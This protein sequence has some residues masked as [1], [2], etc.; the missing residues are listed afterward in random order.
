VSLILPS[1]A[2]HDFTLALDVQ[3]YF[4]AEYDVQMIFD[5]G[6]ARP[7]SLETRDV[8][9]VSRFNG[10]PDQPEFEVWFP[11][12]TLTPK[13]EREALDVLGRI[14]GTTLDTSGF[15]KKVQGDEVLEPLVMEHYGFKRLARAN[16]Y[17][18]A[19][20]RIAHSRISHDPTKKRMVQDIRKSWGTAW[21][22]EGVTY[23][24]YPRPEVLAEVEPQALREL[25]LSL[26]K[27]EYIT[28]L[29]KHVTDNP[30]FLAHM[31]T[32]EPE[33]FLERALG[34]RGIGPSLAQMLLLSRGSSHAVLA[35]RLVKKQ[36][37][38][39]RA[40]IFPR[41]GVDVNEATKAQTLDILARIEGYEALTTSYVYF[42][43][44]NE[45]LRKKHE[46]DSSL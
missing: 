45:E 7:L 44:V 9:S 4:E 8:L 37:K 13:E 28:G 34:I 17:E 6:Y 12:E 36:D 43:W 5:A 40:W 42:D 3:H 27:G 30:D 11:Q 46:K 2:P 14:L 23:Y 26:R 25:G 22:W 1:I 10:D 39:L 19:L 18:D 29:A 31:E 21:T 16:F 32:C 35:E 15:I 24:G 20:R 33:D 38:G 41:F